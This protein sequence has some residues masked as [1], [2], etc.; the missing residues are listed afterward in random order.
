VG[1]FDE[2]EF[3]ERAE[4]ASQPRPD[5]EALK[6]ERCGRLGTPVVDGGQREAL[7]LLTKAGG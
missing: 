6:P 5:F 4:R 3:D 2:R 1:E 7:R